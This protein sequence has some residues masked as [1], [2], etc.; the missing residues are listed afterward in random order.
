MPT[1]ITYN[2]MSPKTRPIA[3][4]AT[5]ATIAVQPCRVII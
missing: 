3:K 2:S 5:A 4:Q 1:P